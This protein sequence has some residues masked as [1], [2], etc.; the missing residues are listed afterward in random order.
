MEDEQNYEASLLTY[1]DALARLPNDEKKVLTYAWDVYRTT[2]DV[3]DYLARQRLQR[4]QE[5]QDSASNNHQQENSQ[6]R[7][8]IP[9]I[10]SDDEEKVRLDS[11]R[12]AEER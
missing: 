10:P 11:E 9:E 4:H 7:V 8:G 3:Q 6:H 12:R 5:A 2:L 1:E